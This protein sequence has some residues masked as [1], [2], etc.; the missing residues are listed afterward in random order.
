MKIDVTSYK[1]DTKFGWLTKEMDIIE[2]TFKEYIHSGIELVKAKDK[3]LEAE[4]TDFDEELHL[5][6]SYEYGIGKLSNYYLEKSFLFS[7]VSYLYSQLELKILEIHRMSIYYLSPEYKKCFELFDFHNNSKNANFEST[8]KSITRFY[9]IMLDESIEKKLKILD[10]FREVRN[11]IVHHDG[12]LN[13]K[14]N[15]KNIIERNSQFGLKTNN[16]EIIIN[17]E[18]LIFIVS[19]IS[20]FLSQLMDLIWD[21]RK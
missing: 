12:E 5:S 9:K 6:D 7:G 4:R 21:N 2:S 1:N 11:L 18:Y 16:N 14:F 15:N 8:L 10:D 3:I 19:N 17:E 20:I 13:D